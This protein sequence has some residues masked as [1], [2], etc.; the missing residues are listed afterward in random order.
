MLNG[1]V[2]LRG[3]GPL[4]TNPTVS[5]PLL[6]F[7]SRLWADRSGV[8]I[9]CAGFLRDLPNFFVPLLDVSL[10]LTKTAIEL[11]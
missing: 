10:D 4:L 11:K 7:H 8:T 5:L 2:S 1:V 3:V 6:S 9:L